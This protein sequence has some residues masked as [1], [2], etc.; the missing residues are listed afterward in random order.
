MIR[1]LPSPTDKREKPGKKAC[2]PVVSNRLIA[3]FTLMA[4][5]SI[6]ALSNLS[7]AE[8]VTGHKV[9][10]NMRNA[11]LAEVFGEMKRQ[12][13]LSFISSTDDLK[14]AKRVNAEYEDTPAT[15]VLD[16]LL[17]NQNLGYKISEDYVTIFRLPP[18]A[19]TPAST[20]ESTRTPFSGR[21]VSAI[22]EP[23]Q[24]VTVLEKGTNNGAISDSE[25]Q[26]S[27]R[28]TRPDAVVI[29]TLLSHEPVEVEPLGRPDMTV[30][31]NEFATGL[32]EVIVVAYGVQRKSSV[33]GAI[34]TVSAKELT[35]VTSPNV[36]TIF[37]IEAIHKPIDFFGFRESCCSVIKVSN[38]THCVHL[39]LA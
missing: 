18:A 33:T 3:A 9:T 6:F 21:V 16:E 26:F 37:T 11:T 20:S 2:H 32:E 36:N 39:R 22:G 27:L 7:A 19:S 10:L 14:N 24:G 34:S 23:L 30:T 31:M 25:G 28:L 8:P 35:T 15:V 4:L 13:G 38:I 1:S 17:K 29:F 5:F 12:T